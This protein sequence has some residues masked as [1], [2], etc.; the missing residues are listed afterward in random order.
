MSVPFIDFTEQNKVIR[1]EVDGPRVCYCVDHR[2]V[3]RLKTLVG[4]L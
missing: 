2:V 3:G 4:R 1:G